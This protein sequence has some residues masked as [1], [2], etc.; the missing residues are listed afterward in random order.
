MFDGVTLN[1]ITLRDLDDLRKNE[2]YRKAIYS[3]WNYGEDNDIIIDLSK[4]VDIIKEQT[5]A[6]IK[7]FKF[8]YV[9]EKVEFDDNIKLE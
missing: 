1:N 7:T 2:E 4:I 3:M 5:L 9:P 8:I 6:R